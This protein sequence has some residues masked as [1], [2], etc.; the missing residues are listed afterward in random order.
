MTEI[1]DRA[2]I[3]SVVFVVDDIERVDYINDLLQRDTVVVLA[4]RADLAADLVRAEQPAVAVIR[5]GNVEID[6]DGRLVHCDGRP[7]AL[8]EQEFGILHCLA[9]QPR[10]AYSFEEILANVWRLTA[11]ATPAIVHSAIRR[12]RGKLDLAGASLRIE[13]A[14]GYGFRLIP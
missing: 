4:P 5:I 12:L 6:L 13:S 7:L 2:G 14:R 3:T 9:R 1:Q 10:R 8:T 11:C